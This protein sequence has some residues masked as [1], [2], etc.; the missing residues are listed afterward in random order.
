MKPGNRNTPEFESGLKS[1]KK[2]GI[3]IGNFII[4][5]GLFRLI[6]MLSE[7]FRKI[8]IYYAGAALFAV[9]VI[10]VF[11]AFFVLNGFTLSKEPRTEEEL[12]ENWT[13]E[14]KEKFLAD[15]PENKKKAQKLLYVIFPLAATLFISFIELNFFK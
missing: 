4:I 11:T 8:W 9:A 1:L 14:Q 5:F 3:L 6:I 13:D 2:I 15:Q 10:A 12:P 7:Y